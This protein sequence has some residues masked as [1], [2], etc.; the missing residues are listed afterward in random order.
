M[1][2]FRLA[3]AALGALVS[4]ELF[5]GM[6]EA[7]VWQ[8]LFDAEVVAAV[9]DFAPQ[10]DGCCV[11]AAEIG[12]KAGRLE[13]VR[14]TVDYAALAT[15]RRPVGLAVRV[16]NFTGAFSADDA[17]T[18]GIAA[19]VRETLARAHAAGLAVPELQV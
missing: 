19:V 13:V 2:P 7:Y 15:L 3:L 18:R 17:T 12:W 6:R 9:R 10:L 16:G 1:R 4:A 14:P 5:A 8:R 11:L